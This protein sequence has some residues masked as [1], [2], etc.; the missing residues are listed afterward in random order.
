MQQLHHT[1][2][3]KNN[4]YRERKPLHVMRDFNAHIGKRTNPTETATGKFGLELRNESRDTLVE[5]ATSRKYKIMNTIFQKTAGR[6]W[7]WKSTSDVSKEEVAQTKM[8]RNMLNITYRE[9]KRNILV[10]EK[11]KVTD[12][13][14]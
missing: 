5:W 8:E 3:K 13:I 10:R 12:V 7:T 2:K 14:E 4:S 6:R 1:Q 11:K 9:R